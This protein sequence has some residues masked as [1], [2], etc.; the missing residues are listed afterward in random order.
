MI[1][2]IFLKEAYE[3]L[4]LKTIRQNGVSQLILNLC[5]QK[6]SYSSDC[7]RVGRGRPESPPR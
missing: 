4:G 6:S 1:A 7:G 3:T 5:Q 2:K